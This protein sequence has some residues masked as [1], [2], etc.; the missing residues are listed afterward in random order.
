VL[1]LATAIEAGIEVDPDCLAKVRD[2]YESC[3]AGEEGRTCY[4]VGR[5]VGT[6]STTGA[7][8]LVH[9][10]LLGQADSALAES[11][12]AYLARFAETNWLASES[13]QVYNDYYLW[14]SCTLAMC[15][16]GGGPWERWNSIVRDAIIRLQERDGCGR[17][18]WDPEA[19]AYGRSKNGAGRVYTTALA[20]LTLEVYYRF[21]EK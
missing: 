7:G 19:S 9:Q 21:A 10:F 1:A 14:H 17:G 13:P 5:G 18:S 4:M 12:V 2:F 6:E 11:A 16:A 3:E 20:V 15:R 8:V